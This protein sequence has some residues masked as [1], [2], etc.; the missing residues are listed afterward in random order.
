MAIFLMMTLLLDSVWPVVGAVLLNLVLIAVVGSFRP[1]LMLAG[2]LVLAFLWM[3]Q[4]YYGGRSEL[5]NNLEIHFW[6]NGRAVISK[7]SSAL[8]LFAVVLY[9]TT[10]N[11]NN[12]AVIKGYFVAMIQPIEPI[13]A[14]YFPVPG[15]SNIIQ[16]ATDKSVNIFYDATVG[17]FLQL[18]DILQKVILF[19]VGIIIFLFIKFSLALVNWPATYL[20][21]G[22]YRL[23]LKFGFFKIELQNRPQKVIVLT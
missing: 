4:A 12:P 5:K 23:L 8:A 6:Q 16:Q 3:V 13:M 9:L 19:V 15:V 14:T 21:Y 18:P 20:A 17:R 22:L 11:F 7:A 1:S 2:A 10:F